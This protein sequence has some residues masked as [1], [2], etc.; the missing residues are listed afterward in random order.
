MPAAGG[1]E[2]HIGLADRDELPTAVAGVC[3]RNSAL[4]FRARPHELSGKLTRLLAKGRDETL[5]VEDPA[6]PLEVDPFILG[7]PLHLAQQRDVARR[8]TAPPVNAVGLPATSRWSCT[9]PRIRS[10]A[11]TATT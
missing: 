3:L 1:P 11:A 2:D 7:E 10:S 5:E 6:D 9:W 8:V 4:D